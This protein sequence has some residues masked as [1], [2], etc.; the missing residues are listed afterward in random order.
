MVATGIVMLYLDMCLIFSLIITF[1]LLPGLY[2]G[3]GSWSCKTKRGKPRI[4]EKAGT[5]SCS[6][7]SW[8]KMNL[9]AALNLHSCCKLSLTLFWL[10]Q[11]QIKELQKNQ[12]IWQHR[13]T[14]KWRNHPIIFL[15]S[16][17]SM[18]YSIADGKLFVSYLSKKKKKKKLFVSHVLIGLPVLFF[19]LRINSFVRFIWML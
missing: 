4:A 19:C 6:R 18:I 14:N 9:L 8:M 10:L 5:I 3:I 1:G 11:A 17:W 12:V 13:M 7:H 2:Y 15:F 16:L